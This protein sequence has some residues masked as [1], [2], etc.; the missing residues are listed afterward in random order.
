MPASRSADNNS[1][2]QENSLSNNLKFVSCS[3]DNQIYEW[4][5]DNGEWKRQANYFYP[6]FRNKVGFHDEWVRDV[7]YA[8]NVIV[9]KSNAHLISQFH[10]FSNFNF[11]YVSTIKE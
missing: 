5:M 8:Q 4:T 9:Y 11:S 1:N 3:C 2:S 6:I 10:R 7:K